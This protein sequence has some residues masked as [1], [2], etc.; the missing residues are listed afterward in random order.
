MKQV[1]P[2]GVGINQGNW[3]YQRVKEFHTSEW[4][5]MNKANSNYVQIQVKNDIK[6]LQKDVSTI[7]AVKSSNT[8][9][10]VMLIDFFTLP[11]TH[12]FISKTRN[13]ARLYKE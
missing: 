9:S 7:Y 3:R 1:T 4:L 5:Q 13:I 8:T 2:I 10:D 11:A 6:T 12:E